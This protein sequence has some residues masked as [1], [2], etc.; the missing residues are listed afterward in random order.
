MTAWAESVELR[1]VGSDSP[2]ALGALAAYFSELD[3]RFPDGFDPG[4]QDPAA[5]RPPHGRF[6]V[7]ESDGEVLACG[8]TQRI[9]DDIAE[10][11]RMWVAEAW[12]GRGLAGRMLR[13]L[14]SSAVADGHGT[15]R[16]DTNPTLMEAIELYRRAGYR[17]IERY[18]DNPYAGVWFEKALET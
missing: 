12:R 7:A 8:A 9:S 4:V 15:I 14:E 10:I 18:N 13:H 16:L 3:A 6:F 17:Q 5:F 2:Q 11:K 1:E